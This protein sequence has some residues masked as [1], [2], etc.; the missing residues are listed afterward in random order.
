[1]ALAISRSDRRRRCRAKFR[2]AERR[3][4]NEYVALFM[5]W[6]AA[7]RR[8]ATALERSESPG[9]VA[10]D[11]AMTRHEAHGKRRGFDFK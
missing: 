11:V 1:V 2:R 4:N 9:V 7:K 10:L 5:A 8:C 6:L 3:W